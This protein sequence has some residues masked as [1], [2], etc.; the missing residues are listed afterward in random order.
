VNVRN[1]PCGYQVGTNGASNHDCVRGDQ[2][3]Q[4]LDEDYE[5][6]LER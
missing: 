1:D 3:E 2:L 6:R 4:S 5:A